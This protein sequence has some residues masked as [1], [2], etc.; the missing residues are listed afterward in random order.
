MRN[1]CSTLVT[2]SRSAASTYVVDRESSGKTMSRE[3]Y[4][5]I[6]AKQDAYIA[7]QEMIPPLP[8]WETHANAISANGTRLTGF[9][10]PSPVDYYQYR[11]F[12][13]NP[14]DA[15]DRWVDFGW[16]ELPMLRKGT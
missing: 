14:D 5:A 13:Y 11:G 3:D 2:L 9:T 8:G 4:D 6:A 12:S 15:I 16:A 10:V 7:E 1:C